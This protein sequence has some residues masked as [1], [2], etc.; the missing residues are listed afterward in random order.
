MIL[1]PTLE[2]SLYLLNLGINPNKILGLRKNY[3]KLG[4]Y[5]PFWIGKQPV[6]GCNIVNIHIGI[7][8]SLA[9]RKKF[10]VVSPYLH[11]STA[12]VEKMKNM[13]E[14]TIIN[15]LQA[16]AK[17]DWHIKHTFHKLYFQ[18]LKGYLYPCIRSMGPEIL[19]TTNLLVCDQWFMS[20]TNWF[21]F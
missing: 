13:T 8:K 14:N 17:N 21:P 7:I 9:V 19:L 11:R 16:R 6:F 1:L 18:M 5:R 2:Y 4:K 12:I 3:Q 20:R 10:Q 15:P